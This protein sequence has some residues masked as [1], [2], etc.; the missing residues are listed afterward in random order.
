MKNAQYKN[1]FL[2]ESS[3]FNA[4]MNNTLIRVKQNALNVK[5]TS[6]LT[7]TYTTV[8]IFRTI[9]KLIQKKHKI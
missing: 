7:K 9:I 3:V 4:K 6:S 5:V 2:L 1:L 8:L